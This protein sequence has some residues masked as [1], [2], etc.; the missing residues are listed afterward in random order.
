[1]V[2]LGYLRRFIAF[3]EQILAEGS[4]ADFAVTREVADFFA[5]TREALAQ[6][7][8]SLE[9]GFSD[10]QRRQLMDALGQTGSAYRTRYY[11]NGF[12]GE[13]VAL[14][15]KDL[16]AFLG[17]A[18]RY[19]E[20]SLKANRRSD[21]LYHAYNILHLGED[22]AS[23]G[24][25]DEM[26]EGQV[27][28]LSSGLLT[29]AE[30]LAVLQGLRNSRLYR[31]DQDSYILYPDRDLPGFLRKN[32]LDESQVAGLALVAKLVAQN[33]RSLIAR[34]IHGV[35]HFNGSFRNDKDVKKALEKL[36]QSADYRE[37]VAAE[38]GSI[39]N[40]FEKT[41]HHLA[42]T[43][44]S[45]TFFAYEGL[46]SIYWH[47]ISKLLLATQ[48]IYFRAA[49]A[50]EPQSVLQPLAKAYQDIRGGLGY[51]KSPEVYGAFPT[52]P[53]SHTPAGQGAKQPGMTGQVKEEILT[54][55]S[56][57]GLFVEN[58]VIF[59]NPLQLPANEL[60]VRPETFRYTDVAGRE[61]RL[62]LPAGS[63]AFTFCQVPVVVSAGA[64]EILRI[65]FTDG[66]VQEIAGS[67]LDLET[68]Q[69][70]FERAHRVET[71]F[72]QALHL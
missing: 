63:L 44:R 33:D 70:I 15:P 67:A 16:L 3:F 61:Q 52:D 34:D 55:L 31:A 53:Y 51:H 30:S 4:A 69:A 9:T 1:V 72:Y 6:S 37:L 46:G 12:S 22:Q 40:L 59:F 64:E 50:A 14:E 41:F 19:V 42:F 47:M 57:L 8:A 27:S 36:G 60:L 32:C 28:I 35:Y 71:I 21:D 45:G 25:L 24:H 18:R 13:F 5:A 26:L 48:E 56:E 58:G 20:Q 43:G 39:L 49:R 11:A 10:G 2:T 7:A 66:S 17:L 54:R 23:I 38:T 65:R 62:D 68:S 29:S